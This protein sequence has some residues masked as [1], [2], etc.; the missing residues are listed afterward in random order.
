VPSPDL[1]LSI[2]REAAA[3]VLFPDEVVK[4]AYYYSLRAGERV[5][6]KRSDDDKLDRVVDEIRANLNAGNLPPDSLE[7]D[8]LQAVCR[9]CAFDLVCRRG[10]R[11]DRKLD[12]EAEP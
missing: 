3:Q 12:L 10:P 6:A 9:W 2:Y 4:D 7:R 8:P 11:L 1:Q 5:R